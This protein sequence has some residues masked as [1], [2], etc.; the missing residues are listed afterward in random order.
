MAGR[1]NLV[2]SGS[3]RSPCILFGRS[4]RG[5][6]CGAGSGGLEPPA[7]GVLEGAERTLGLSSRL[8]LL[9]L[10]ESALLCRFKES[11]EE[12]IKIYPY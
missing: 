12:R 5:L 8:G 6:L 7:L 10:K 2:S 4:S 11:I 1:D 9:D 3:L